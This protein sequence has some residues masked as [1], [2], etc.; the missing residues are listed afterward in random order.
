MNET[1]VI[2]Q[3]IRNHLVPSEEFIYGFA[4]LNGLLDKEFEAYSYAVS[5][6][7]RLNNNIIDAIGNGPTIEYFNHYNNINN[8]L[9]DLSESICR[10]F[11]NHY[12][13]CKNI[14]PTVPTL[15]EDIPYL[16]TLRYKISHKMVA[17]RA[18]LGWVGKTDLFI[19]KVFG[20]RLRLTSILFDKPVKISHPTIDK[21][22][23]GKCDICVTKCPAQ[24]AT[25]ALW[26][27]YTDRDIY[28]DAHKCREKCGELTKRLI[29][30]D[31][32]ICGICISVCPV[33]RKNN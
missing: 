17:T 11:K 8:E 1:D 21:S 7:K 15:S 2:E 25:G 9:I 4:D 33:G 30:K 16:K 12:I 20:P 10:E 31:S 13:N 18:G 32:H 24:A 6:G 29:N 19:S 5:I 26:D 14:L 28:F 22:R 3:I 27:I 23:C